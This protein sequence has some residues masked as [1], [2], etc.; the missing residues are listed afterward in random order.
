MLFSEFLK[1][2][3]ANDE[4]KL[5]FYHSEEYFNMQKII[6]KDYGLRKLLFLKQKVMSAPVGMSV[7]PNRFYEVFDET[8]QWLITGGIVD[9]AKK[10]DIF[11]EAGPIEEE[12]AGPN[13]LGF[14]DLSHGFAV[15]L[16][17]CG[18]SCICL[19]IEKMLSQ[20][21]SFA[22]LV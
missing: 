12:K 14:N 5:A 6:F 13:V 4:L 17:T 21:T 2:F 9:W 8:V 1:Y 11:N 7:F 22:N 20:I 19:I 18:I 15:W 10:I 3:H 16:A